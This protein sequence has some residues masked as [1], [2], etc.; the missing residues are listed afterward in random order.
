MLLLLLSLEVVEEVVAPA[1]ATTACSH[2]KG[3][4]LM[5]F[6]FE[7]Q[8]Q[9]EIYIHRVSY[10]TALAFLPP[11]DVEE[12]GLLFGDVADC[13]EIFKVVGEVPYKIAHHSQPNYLHNNKKFNKP[14]KLYLVSPRRPC[15]GD[16]GRRR[17]GRRP[18]RR[19]P[20]RV[21]RRGDHGLLPRARRRSLRNV[22]GYK[23]EVL[24]VFP[25]RL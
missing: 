20:R 22:I 23:V 8:N 3:Q 14:A 24:I 21:D 9:H 18:A 1:L 11:S 5:T 10:L 19:L 2:L 7:I 4:H 12:E 17:R 6:E 15:V 16:G 25:G 13:G